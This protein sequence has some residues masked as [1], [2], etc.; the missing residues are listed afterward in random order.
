M[1]RGA[2]GCEAREGRREAG[3]G[4]RLRVAEVFRRSGAKYVAERGASRKQRQAVRDITLCRTEA[5]GGNARRC[6]KCGHVEVHYS[7]CRNRHCPTCHAVSRAK[8]TARRK[9]A[10]LGVG[11]FFVTFTVPEELRGIARQ[12]EREFYGAM[13]EAAAQTVGELGKDSLGAQM[14]VTA[15]LH[16]WGRDMSYHPHVHSVVTAGGLSNEEQRWVA[17][18]EQFLFPFEQLKAVY[19]SRMLQGLRQLY[20]KG[21]LAFPGELTLVGRPWAFE[22]LLKQLWRKKWVVDVQSPRGRPENAIK[23]LGAYTH[24]VAISDRRL[25]SLGEGEV[26]F[27]T[28][29]EKKVTLTDEEF[30]RR[31]LMHVL[32]PRFHKIRHYGLYASQSK[33]QLQKARELLG[34]AAEEPEEAEEFGDDDALL[35]EAESWEDVVAIVTGIDPRCCPRCGHQGMIVTPLP[36]RPHG[37]K[38]RDSGDTS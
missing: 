30:L 26:C 28:R 38:Q 29:G 7:S 34:Q 12:N 31:F 13:F 35:L 21:K 24:R 20:A 2:C 22:R 37:R 3:L 19:R 27:C 16:T 18:R 10:I 14:G 23:Y 17:T 25:V 15:V 33:K 36:P 9:A 1:A 32:P 5:L 8:W 6:P 11:H 4:K